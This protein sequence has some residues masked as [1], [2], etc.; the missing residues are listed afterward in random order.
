MDFRDAGELARDDENNET[1][2]GEDDTRTGRGNPCEGRASEEKEICDF[3]SDKSESLRD[4]HRTGNQSV[5]CVF[6]E[7]LSKSLGTSRCDSPQRINGISSIFPVILV[8]SRRSV[9]GL[10]AEGYVA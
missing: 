8:N 5:A 9:Q 6:T 7:G 2:E 4:D 10:R 3:S 1:S